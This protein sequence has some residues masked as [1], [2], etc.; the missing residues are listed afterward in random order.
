MS[1]TAKPGI[2]DNDALLTYRVGP[3][4]CCGPTLPIV[5]ITPPPSRLTRPPGTSTAEPGIFKHGPDIVSA[6][7]L[8]YRFG[9]KQENWKQPGQVIITKH[10]D[11]TR[12]YFVDEIID[13][14]HFPETGWGQLPAYLPRGIFSRTLV[15]NKKIYLYVEFD[16]L[17]RLQGSGYLSKYIAHLEDQQEKENKTVTNKPVSKNS[18]EAKEEKITP[19]ISPPKIKDTRT[20]NLPKENL[21]TINKQILPTTEPENKLSA[22][23]DAASKNT[24]KTTIEKNTTSNPE[25]KVSV[26]PILQTH[27]KYNTKEDSAQHKIKI[28]TDKPLKISSRENLPDTEIK[29]KTYQPEKSDNTKINTRQIDSNTNNKTPL[30]AN[31]NTTNI[32]TQTNETE[33]NGN[34]LVFMLMLLMLILISGGGYYYFLTPAPLDHSVKNTNKYSDNIADIL[35]TKEN[36]SY[37]EITLPEETT[38]QNTTNNTPSSQTIGTQVQAAMPTTPS[39]TA[40]KT[41]GQQNQKVSPDNNQAEYSA[42]IHQNEDT[43]TIE[44]KGPLPPDVINTRPDVINKDNPDTVEK[45]L[46]SQQTLSNSKESTEIADIFNNEKAQITT[47]PKKTGKDLSME[48]IHIIVKGDTLW[49][50]AKHYLQNPFLYPELAKLSKIKNPD[51]IYPGNRVRIIYHPQNKNRQK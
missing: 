34:V 51:L 27:K 30:A 40:N 5:T 32:H 25:T 49:A 45:E 18:S 31:T 21:A 33:Q 19:K 41:S 9:V 35:P 4:L 47:V 3:V 17:S 13:V 38:Q 20:K 42:N 37:T 7:D 48:I 14:S 23:S 1:L 28:S 6:T 39:E 22:S 12:G 24:T 50:I 11:I 2:H 16:K 44:L 36:T 29:I 10:N 26:K 8:R 46:A 15:I 43:I